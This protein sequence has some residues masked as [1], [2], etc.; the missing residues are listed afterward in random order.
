MKKKVIS[1]FLV[2]AMVMVYSVP[3]FAKAKDN[4]EEMPYTEESTYIDDEGNTIVEKVIDEYDIILWLNQKSDEELKSIGY[5]NKEIQGIREFMDNTNSSEETYG[6]FKY[7]VE[8][9]DYSYNKDKKKTYITTTV[10]WSWSK[11]PAVALTDIVGTTIAKGFYARTDSD[12]EIKG[13]A[14]INYYKNGVKK[15]E[16]KYVSNRSIKVP[17][18]MRGTYIKVPVL[19][20]K[21]GVEYVAMGGAITTKW[22]ASGKKTVI[23]CG[24]KYGHS[25]IKCTPEIS[26]S[27]AGVAVTISPSKRCVSGDLA[28]DCLDK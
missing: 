27:N 2:F 10:K 15:K 18:S 11:K 6:K 22:V 17:N 28:Y 16:N 12:G 4:Y 13:S 24:G 20:K 1:L 3:C 8:Y 14:H 5:K 7:S 19:T 25:I 21:N 26:F 23:P 9:S